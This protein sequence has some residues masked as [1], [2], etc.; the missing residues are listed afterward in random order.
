MLGDINGGKDEITKISESSVNLL[1]AKGL[2]IATFSSAVSV[3]ELNDYFK[4]NNRS[5]ILFE[6]NRGSYAAFINDGKDTNEKLFEKIIKN[7]P[8]ILE[9]MSVKLLKDIVT[10][11]KDIKHVSKYSGTSV[12]DAIIVTDDKIMVESIKKMSSNEKQVEINKLIDKGLDK[13]TD[14]DKKYLSCLTKKS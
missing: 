7:N 8:D 1:Q 9:D 13:L 12:S 4:L 14:Y 5:F 11:L 2:I 6:M 3:N 10:S